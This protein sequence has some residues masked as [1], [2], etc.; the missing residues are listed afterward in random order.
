MNE[1]KNLN[2]NTVMLTG[3]NEKSAQEAIE[4]LNHTKFKGNEI[5]ISI[6]TPKSKR[7]EDKGKVETVLL[8]KKLPKEIENEEQLTEKFQDFGEIL[9]NAII[10]ENESKMGII[11]FSKNEQAEKAMESLKSDNRFEMSITPATDELIEKINKSKAEI[12]KKKFEGLNLVIKNLPKEINDSSYRL[13]QILES[14]GEKYVDD[15]PIKI[16]LKSSIA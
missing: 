6:F 8:I 14:N 16:E 13:I 7:D 5:I 10:E 12:R 4:K 9:G 2:Y 1:L 11:I 3:D 15:F